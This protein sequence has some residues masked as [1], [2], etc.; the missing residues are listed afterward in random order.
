M[1][2]LKTRT[3]IKKTWQL[4]V[5]RLVRIKK[6]VLRPLTSSLC[7]FQE[8][9]SKKSRKVKN[10]RLKPRKSLCQFKGLKSRKSRKVKHVRLKQM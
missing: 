6:L 2:F 8:M 7:Q 5:P 1:R 4:L 10:V 3:R 9:K